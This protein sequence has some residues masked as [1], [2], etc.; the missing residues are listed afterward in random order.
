MPIRT[1]DEVAGESGTLDGLFTES[2]GRFPERPAL[3]LGGRSW[4]YNT[5][6]AECDTVEK[7]LSAAGL[8]GTGCHVGLIYA[9]GA[10]SY[11]SIIA[12]MR[13]HNVYVPLNAKLPCERLLTMIDDA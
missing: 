4:T 5:L 2:L 9:K 10:F 3:I 7:L 12:I 13:S 6:N 1:V 11:A 8:S